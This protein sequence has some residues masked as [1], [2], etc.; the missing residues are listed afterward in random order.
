MNKSQ[1]KEKEKGHKRK[2]FR[3][4]AQA[5]IDSLREATQ[6][7]INTDCKK[8]NV[9]KIIDVEYVKRNENKVTHCTIVGKLDLNT[10]ISER[11]E[12]ELKER[13]PAITSF[14]NHYF[15]EFEVKSKVILREGDIY[16]KHSGEDAAFAS[17]LIKL[18]S[19]V[20]KTIDIINTVIMRHIIKRSCLAEEFA[21]AVEKQKN[22]LS[23]Y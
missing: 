1:S 10:I 21:K 5:S 13:V 2:L 3:E 4:A 19:S 11:L 16:N 18:Y 15:I 12:K 23:K 6:G 17:A 22:I 14:P 9:L 7:I 20:K 8:S